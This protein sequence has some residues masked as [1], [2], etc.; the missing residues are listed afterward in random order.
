VADPAALERRQVASRV[1]YCWI[2]YVVVTLCASHVNGLAYGRDGIGKVAI[3]NAVLDLTAGVLI[4]TLLFGN[5]ASFAMMRAPNMAATVL[6]ATIL[7]AG[8][9]NFAITGVT[10]RPLTWNRFGAL[11]HTALIDITVLFGLG[12]GFQVFEA[13]RRRELSESRL[14]T[15][16]ARSQVQLLRA[17]LQPHFLFNSLHA[18]SSRVTTAPAVAQ[19]MIARLGELLHMSMDTAAGP[20]TTLRE[21]MDFV[22]AYLDL[23]QFRFGERL[24]IVVEMPEEVLD[25][26]I[27]SFILQPAVENSIRHVVERVDERVDVGIVAS[28]NE[29][30]L[31]VVVWNTG[32]A[33]L[34]EN[35]IHPHLGIGNTAERLRQIYGNAAGVTVANRL[36]GGV[37]TEIHLPFAAFESGAVV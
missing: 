33:L 31:R 30:V 6:V 37:K 11:F 36:Q 21:E 2:V 17:Q 25:A 34:D 13:N 22:G 16:L 15:E 26:V 3:A 1:L 19:S 32:P 35:R 28:V 7:L 9:Q 29:Q 4:A 24:R 27:P 23:Q 10:Q 20:V 5:W 18:I 8:A 14:E 12:Y